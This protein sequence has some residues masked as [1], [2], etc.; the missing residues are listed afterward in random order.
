MIF[1]RIDYIAVVI[2]MGT[3]LMLLLTQNWRRYIVS[4][5]LQFVGV[6]W[7]IGLVLPIGLAA[8]KLIVGWM[9]GAVLAASQPSADLVY[10]KPNPISGILFRILSTIMVW[11]LC[12]S[13]S[14][15]MSNWI[16]ADQAIIRGA[17]VLIGMGLLQLG[18][19]TR[20]LRVIV[21]LLMLLSGFDI[22]YS[23]LETSVLVAG[24][25]AMINLGLALV[26]SFLLIGSAGEFSS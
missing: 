6:F 12:F 17:L 25:L 3:S 7:L 21:A 15:S 14:P 23:S 20:P 22:I 19:T 8:V 9:A 11:V 2:L 4:F 13:I 1:Q 24:L 10:E 18:M 26:G 16:S 5:S